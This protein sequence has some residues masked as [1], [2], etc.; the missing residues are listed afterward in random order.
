MFGISDNMTINTNTDALFITL[1]APFGVVFLA[2]I[3]YSLFERIR[4]YRTERVL[5]NTEELRQAIKHGVK[6]GLTSLTQI[7]NKKDTK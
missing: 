1:L 6:E 2:S 7:V 3:G 4:K 5:K